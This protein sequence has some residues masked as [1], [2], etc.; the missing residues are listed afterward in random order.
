MAEESPFPSSETSPLSHKRRITD[1]VSPPLDHETIISQNPTPTLSPLPSF[2]AEPLILEVGVTEIQKNDSSA[3]QSPKKAKLD[4]LNRSLSDEGGIT[5]EVLQDSENFSDML[6]LGTDSKDEL[7]ILDGK[8]EVHQ[9]ELEKIDKRF[10]EID[11]FLGNKNENPTQVSSENSSGTAVSE[12][13]QLEYEK[14]SENFN[15]FL[16]KFVKGGDSASSL[17]IEMIDGTLLLGVG[18]TDVPMTDVEWKRNRNGGK[19]GNPRNNTGCVAG[20]S[21]KGKRKSVYSRKDMEEMR[22]VNFKGQRKFW[23][24]IYN[25]FSATVKKEYVALGSCQHQ[26]AGGGKK[27]C[28]NDGFLGASCST[29]PNFSN[30]GTMGEWSEGEESDDEYESMHRPAFK[31]Q[32]EPDFESGSPEDGLEYLR[33]VRWEAKRIPKV[34]VAKLNIKVKDQSVYMPGIPDIEECPSHL[35]PLRPWED[36]FIADFSELRLALS[37][38]ENTSDAVSVDSES[39][40][41]ARPEH[42][43]QP[44]QK[45]ASLQLT[46]GGPTLS[47]VL[48]MDPVTRVAL[49][50]RR[51]SLFENA[52]DL[53][54]DDCAWLFALCAVVDTPLDADTCASLRCL[55]RSCA[56]F[57]ASKPEVDD[58]VI[59]L[60]VLATISG[61]FFRQ[62]E[63]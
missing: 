24:E 62:S 18:G 23:N 39:I 15:G 14:K 52:S 6:Q 47:S 51:I 53:S 4:T 21:N 58:E 1:M 60:N 59:M 55:L 38:L 44:S 11:E 5:D 35:L 28:N 2:E 29:V 63:N 12:I 10:E 43:S 61:R 36:E 13:V 56:K 27:N 50:R 41:F 48:A 49:L 30:R 25:G 31:V 33:R 17:K 40:I 7:L 37:R 3:E 32:G 26:Q 46:S 57:R 8:D 22:Y 45:L 42:K 19:K 20:D 16:Q 54:K 34:K 9:S